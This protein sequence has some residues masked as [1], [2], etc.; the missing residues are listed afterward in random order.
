M[1]IYIYIYVYIYIYIC[2]Y[3]YTHNEILYSH[4]KNETIP[5]AA[6]WMDLE[7]MI[8]DEVNQTEKDKHYMISLTCEI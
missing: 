4:K 1:Y 3:I 6:P 5:S 8:P 7:I 2:I